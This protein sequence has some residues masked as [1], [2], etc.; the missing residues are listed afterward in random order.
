MKSFDLYAKADSMV[1]QKNTTGALITLVSSIFMFFL[2]ISEYGAYKEIRVGIVDVSKVVLVAALA[3][4]VG[5]PV[6]HVVSVQQ[7]FS[8][9]QRNRYVRPPKN[10]RSIWGRLGGHR[11]RYI[12]KEEKKKKR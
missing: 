12:G 11:L 3:G 8:N 6:P 10:G 1:L 9:P 4:R 2:F 7:F 5:P